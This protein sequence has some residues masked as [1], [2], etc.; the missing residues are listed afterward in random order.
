MVDGPETIEQGDEKDSSSHDE[1]GR[2]TSVVLD[3]A[4][5]MITDRWHVG[6]LKF[7]VLSDDVLLY[8]FDAYQRR[9]RQPAYEWAYAFENDPGWPWHTMV[10]VCQRWRRLIFAWPNHLE[11]RVECKSR[12]AVAKALDIWPALPISIQSNLDHEDGGDV[13]AA[14]EHRERI[15]WIKLLDLSGPRLEKCVSLMQGPFPILRCLSLDCDANDVLVLTDA[16]LAGSASHLQLLRLSGVPFPTLPKLL[17]SASKLVHIDLND[18]TS[19]GYVSPEAMAT[20][21]ATLKSLRS[22]V[23][24]FQS[25]SSFLDRTSRLSPPPT[26]GVLPGLSSFT[27]TGVSEYLEDLIARIDTPQ[28]NFFSP[29]FFYQPIFDIPQLPQFIHRAEKLKLPHH[30]RIEFCE[31][32]VV[33]SLTSREDGNSALRFYCTGLYRQLSLLVH[34]LPLLSRIDTLELASCSP[35]LYGRHMPWLDFL[36]IFDA[37]KALHVDYEQLEMQFVIATAL[38]EIALEETEE[39]L[40]MLQII[41]GRF[42]LEE[43]EMMRP[44]LHARSES[45]HPVEVMMWLPVPSP[46]Q[47]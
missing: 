7:D 21:L 32:A 37:V 41:V 14:L 35:L 24:K 18:I 2:R 43:F 30:A 17:L 1:Q 19:A 12:T 34:S 9:S 44:F 6:H 23:I 20:C 42:D 36:R 33:I 10:H 29:Q 25:D 31:D 3:V 13:I 22:L 8:I 38:A 39:V 16:F 40:P 4:P 26:R 27:I 28:L 47:D 46:D 15:A 45:G 11:V 5:V